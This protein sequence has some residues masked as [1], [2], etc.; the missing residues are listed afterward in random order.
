MSVS[1]SVIPDYTHITAEILREGAAER[2]IDDLEA[3]ERLHADDQKD[4]TPIVSKV[5]VG[6]LIWCD[7][8]KVV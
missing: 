3:D 7:P 6:P 1:P 4:H 2:E 8:Q 5:L